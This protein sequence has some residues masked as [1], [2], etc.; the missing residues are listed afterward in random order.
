MKTIE[1]NFKELPKHKTPIF[2]Y[3]RK[4]IAEGEDYN[5]R[6]EIYRRDDS[7]DVAVSKIGEGAKLSVKEN[8]YVHFI[9]Y[10]PSPFVG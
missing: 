4:L 8:P 5:T 1:I 9:K 10:N 3:C 7:F 6:L 2:A